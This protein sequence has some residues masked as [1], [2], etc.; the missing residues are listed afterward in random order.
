MQEHQQW[1]RTFPKL[2][3]GDLI[4]LREDDMTP[5][6][7]PKAVIKETHPGK[8][9]IVRVFTVRIPKGDFERPIVKI[10]LLPRVI[11]EQVCHS[12]WGWLYVT[13]NG[14]GLYKAKA[15]VMIR[16]SHQV[17]CYLVMC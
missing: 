3:P 11:R 2:Q 4:L 14:S 1:H 15:G 7:Q 17:L 6:N 12:F 13:T 16:Q 9:G 8:Y 10:C 5:L